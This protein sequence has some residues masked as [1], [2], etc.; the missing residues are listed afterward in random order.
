M[1][2]V[3]T[4]LLQVVSIFDLI[5]LYHSH[6]VYF[7]SFLNLVEL[8]SLFGQSLHKLAVFS[9]LQ[10]TLTSLHFVVQIICYHH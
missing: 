4:H 5:D 6:L 8:L 7:A 10:K 9:Q 3:A 1:D 2:A